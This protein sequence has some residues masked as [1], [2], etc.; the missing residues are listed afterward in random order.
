MDWMS[1]YRSTS[2]SSPSRVV[3]PP[4]EMLERRMAARSV[5]RVATWGTWWDSPSHFMVSRVLYRK[6]GLSWACIIRSWVSFSSRCRWT[7]R[8]RF[9]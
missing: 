3:K 5:A 6:C 2:S 1:R 8:V 9:S 7:E 4:P